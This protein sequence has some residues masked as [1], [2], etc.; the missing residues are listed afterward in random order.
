MQILAYDRGP[1]NISDSVTKDML[2]FENLNV[3]IS[4]LIKYKSQG[5][6]LGAQMSVRFIS[7]EQLQVAEIGMMFTIYLEGWR[8]FLETMQDKD[9][10]VNFITND[11]C[12]IKNLL[13]ATNAIVL[14]REIGTIMEGY[15][16][17]CIVNIDEF[18]MSAINVEEIAE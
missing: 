8:E 9:E 14:E 12:V 6:V 5:G 4:M 2:N 7:G 16:I 1:L 18:K 15:F 10:I 13:N 17:P 3:Q 11:P